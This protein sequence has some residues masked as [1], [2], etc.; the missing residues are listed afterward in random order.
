[1]MGELVLLPRCGFDEQAAGNEVRAAGVL[2]APASP[3]RWH[4][5]VNICT[6]V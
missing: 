5:F 6:S 1:M 4:C 2:W 3:P